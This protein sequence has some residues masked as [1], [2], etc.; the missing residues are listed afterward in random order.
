[1]SASFLVINTMGSLQYTGLFSSICLTKF[2]LSVTNFIGL[3]A[4]VGV[5]P[6]FTQT[7][8]GTLFRE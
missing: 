5:E 6:L 8:K 7:L 1:M 4:I 3:N 2:E